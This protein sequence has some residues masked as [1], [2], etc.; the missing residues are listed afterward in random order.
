MLHSTAKQASSATK[1]C[2]DSKEQ[3]RTG[4][5]SIVT[6]NMNTSTVK[7]SH[8]TP[9]YH[10]ILCLVEAADCDQVLEMNFAGVVLL[11]TRSDEQEKSLSRHQR[12]AI[13]KQARS[14][15][16]N[17]KRLAN[18]RSIRHIESKID[19][20]SSD[21]PPT[22]TPTPTVAEATPAKK[23]QNRASV[24]V[25]P[26]P[27]KGLPTKP[28][29]KKK[30][31][32]MYCAK[33]GKN[34]LDSPG[35][36][37]HLI[38]K[39]PAES[40]SKNP[41]KDQVVRRS[42]IILLREEAM[43]RVGVSRYFEKKKYVCEDHQLE[44][45]VKRKLVHYKGNKF[46]QSYTLVVPCG[47]GTKSSL[48]PSEKVSK[49]RGC[50]RALRMIFDNANK[51]EVDPNLHGHAD[52]LD[53][54]VQQ[55]ELEYQHITSAEHKIRNLEEQNLARE[56]KLELANANVVL[57]SKSVQQI[58]EETSKCNHRSINSSI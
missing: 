12:I 32:G 13:S 35:V 48:S 3:V 52:E 40:K 54:L 49:G 58:S 7:P 17:V 37:F 50:D 11:S 39:Y 2:M 45:V 57:A 22:P 56:A 34:N 38:P 10:R 31:P 24:S 23:E 21:D 29:T 44:M 33:C 27:M 25:T 4:D 8:F 46:V 1:R 43:D 20:I 55:L 5:G 16:N 15:W 14:D 30:K 9:D 41:R 53:K 26:S 18:K 42:G 28:W 36:K 19:N 47:E 6:T 51:S